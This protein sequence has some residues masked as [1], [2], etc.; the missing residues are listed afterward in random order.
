[1]THLKM[2]RIIVNKR[3][4][5]QI[6]NFVTVVNYSLNINDL[7]SSLSSKSSDRK[8]LVNIRD[9]LKRYFKQTGIIIVNIYKYTVYI[10]FWIMIF[11]P[12]IIY[13]CSVKLDFS[14]SY[15]ESGFKIITMNWNI[16]IS[17][18]Y[19][20]IKCC[21][22][23]KNIDEWLI[24]LKNTILL[25]KS[26]LVTSYTLKHDV[27]RCFWN[28]AWLKCK[29]VYK[30]VGSFINNRVCQ[31]VNTTDLIVIEHYIAI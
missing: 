8:C 1:V 6:L 12:N 29:H 5:A 19:E 11:C 26:Q 20:W 18:I 21:P 14:I 3:W 27:N 4:W 13:F 25:M 17:C 28:S 10:M 2:L 7:T 16:A 30:P 23:R 22:K 24:L 9:I 15:K 31:Y